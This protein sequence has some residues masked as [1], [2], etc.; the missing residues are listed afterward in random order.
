MSF[1][2]L[3]TRWLMTT[4][5][6]SDDPDV[7]PLI[8]GQ[9]FVAA[10]GP[11]WST[12]VKTAASGRQVRASLQAQPVWTFKVAYE[13]IRDRAPSQPD[14]AR[15][16]GFFNT[17]RGQ[18][19]SFL[20]FDPADNLVADQPVGVGDG[21]TNSFQLTRTV[22][23]G[24]P[25]AFVEPVY[26]VN[27]TPEITVGGEPAT[28]VTIA[29]GMATFPI[30]PPPGAEISWSGSFMFWCRFTDDA[31]TPQQMVKSLWSLSGGLSFE[32]LIP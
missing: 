16:F 23:P 22:A 7:F 2:Y 4:P 10:K 11:R 15:L 14:L 31:L 29:Q 1:P 20:Y 25:Y 19:G 21:V 17:R 32:S 13:F 18:F 12:T 9:T 8:A 6:L 24:S 27:G 5:D 30:A 28:G 26:A 3:P